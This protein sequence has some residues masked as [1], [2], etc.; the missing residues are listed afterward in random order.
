[1]KVYLFLICFL[2]LNNSIFSQTIFGNW[3]SDSSEY[4]LVINKEGYSKLNNLNTM[5]IK[6][7]KDKL[8]VV[9]CYG[10]T[11][12]FKRY[13]TW[14]DILK[15]TNDTLI[16]SNIKVPE[17]ERF[18]EMGDSIIVFTKRKSQCSI[19]LN[20]RKEPENSVIINNISIKCLT[21]ASMLSQLTNEFILGAKK[22]FKRSG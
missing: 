8:I 20:F 11:R 12:V 3:Y 1:M 18:E 17:Y 7:K 13:K 6:R 15:L 10:K 2:F 14:Y 16:L 19:I 9:Y 4:C 21:D 22:E 5:I